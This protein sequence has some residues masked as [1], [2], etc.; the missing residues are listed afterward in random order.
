MSIFCIEFVSATQGIR[1]KL[2]GV[3]V[4]KKTKITIVFFS[5]KILLLLHFTDIAQVKTSSAYFIHHLLYWSCIQRW[6]HLQ[7]VDYGLKEASG[8]PV[9][10]LD[11]DSMLQI[12]V[13]QPQSPPIYPHSPTAPHVSSLC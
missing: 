12:A 9:D 2:P 13:R 4:H 1:K 7:G 10:E 3:T 11:S 8:G 5:F 6:H